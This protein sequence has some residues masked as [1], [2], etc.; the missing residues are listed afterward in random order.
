MN[1]MT[2]LY[3]AKSSLKLNRMVLTKFTEIHILKIG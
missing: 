2:V 1:L 3:F